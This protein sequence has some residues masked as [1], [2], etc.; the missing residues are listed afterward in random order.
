MILLGPK[1]E[2]VDSHTK[3]AQLFSLCS[4]QSAFN[5]SLCNSSFSR[6]LPL[7]LFDTDVCSSAA[8]K[9]LELFGRVDILINNAGVDECHQSA[10]WKQ[11]SL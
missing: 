7:D 8:E 9:A 4:W 10:M 2:I 1:L 11:T 3:A 5:M 6:I